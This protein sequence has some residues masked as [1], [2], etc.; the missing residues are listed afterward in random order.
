ME[1]RP[2]RER[3]KPYGVWFLFVA[4]AMEAT[5]RIDTN[6]YGYT[7]LSL[8]AATLLVLL[9]GAFSCIL[10]KKPRPFAP[11]LWSLAS[12]GASVLGFWF[13]ILATWRC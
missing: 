6:V 11:V 2:L 12:V 9:V 5:Y 7:V 8:G 13:L 10:A 4:A 3:A 1:K